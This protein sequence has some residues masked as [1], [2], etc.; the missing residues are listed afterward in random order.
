MPVPKGH[1]WHS[2]G[3][4]L[5][6]AAGPSLCGL[7][8]RGR[9]LRAWSSRKV[10][11]SKGL[12]W[13]QELQGWAE[14]GGLCPQRPLACLGLGVND[15]NHPSTGPPGAT[16]F[17]HVKLELLVTTNEPGK[18]GTLGVG[19]MCPDHSPRG[20]PHSSA[21]GSI[22]PPTPCSTGAPSSARPGLLQATVRMTGCWW[23]PTAGPPLHH[24][25]P[26]QFWAWSP[27]ASDR[28][29]YKAEPHSCP[30]HTSEENVQPTHSA[31]SERWR[32][33]QWPG[34]RPVVSRL[35]SHGGLGVSGITAS[36]DP[37]CSA[38]ANAERVPGSLVRG[39]LRRA[40][41]A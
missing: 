37:R 11:F 9:L 1:L 2:E 35:H 3:P 41:G 13:F 26:Q 31:S 14:T 22:Q 12:G 4:R 40:Q 16:S 7:F 30:F 6:A 36:S 34:L 33:A 10:C 5:P 18:L 39:V 24:L 28:T 32:R 29:A 21:V 15:G 23:S 25:A 20:G 27:A 8:P 19:D 38:L 17:L